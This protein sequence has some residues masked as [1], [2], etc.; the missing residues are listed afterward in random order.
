[1]TDSEP[2]WQYGVIR[3]GAVRIGIPIANLMEVFPKA[4][5]TAL[6]NSAELQC[7]GVKLR[8]QTI[9]L[10]DIAKVGKIKRSDEAQDLGVV[11]EHENELVA[12]FVDE[13]VG[14]VR[15]TPDMFGELTD[16]H[17]RQTA[18]FRQGFPHESTFVATLDIPRL[19]KRPGLLTTDRMH[20]AAMKLEER[21]PPMMTFQ[22]GGAVYAVPAIEVYAAVPK[23]VIAETA[24][25]SGPCLGEITYHDRH[26]PVVCPVSLIGLGD[27]AAQRE[28]EIVVMRFPDDLV[29]GFAV[30]AIRDIQNF[31]TSRVCSLPIT[32]SPNGLIANVFINPEGEQFYEID[33]ARLRAQDEM[34]EIAELSRRDQTEDDSATAS[35][36]MT[37]ASQSGSIT[38]ERER[39]LLVEAHEALAIPLLQ[40]TCILN[41]PE[42]LTPVNMASAGFLGYFS[43]LGRSIGLID[44]SAR[45]GYG[46]VQ[47]KNARILL[48]EQGDRQIGFL[49]ERVL[50]IE[51]S[52]WR[53]V[54]PDTAI[55]AALVQ[56]N[57][58]SG[59]KV[60]PYCDLLQ[61]L[62]PP[63]A[64]MH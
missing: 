38:R 26:V 14:I 24:I 28:S 20:A 17:A 55:D 41:R 43:R 36:S 60:A 11:V 3:I 2:S 63:E 19:F 13:I 1:M 56:L 64:A 32:Q 8:G 15:V 7:G 29:L 34:K 27:G 12:F 54:Q 62:P 35:A 61:F 10:L 47:A 6:P 57:T 33:V 44:L 18:L 21:R 58:N 5:Q 16:K 50:G 4:D 9:P 31:A 49:V 39:Y 46:P 42:R 40:V 30:D 45:C 23:Q 51:V 53:E 22:A 59:T 37:T 52:D 25:T 48:T